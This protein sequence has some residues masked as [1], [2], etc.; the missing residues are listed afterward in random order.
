M[1]DLVIKENELMKVCIGEEGKEGYH[2]YFALVLNITRDELTKNRIGWYVKFI[3][4]VMT[5]TGK[6]ISI[7]W[8]LND[9]HLYGES[10]TMQGV[11]IKLEKFQVPNLEVAKKV[12][13]INSKN[14]NSFLKLVK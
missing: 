2:Y 6:T 13:E 8:Q 11:P 12:E 14:K 9:E 10:F 3:P 5:S 4:L 7:T 1:Q